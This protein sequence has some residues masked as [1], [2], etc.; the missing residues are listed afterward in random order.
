[1]DL[2]KAFY[3]D[4]LKLHQIRKAFNY[5]SEHSVSVQKFKCLEKVR[6]VVKHKTLSYDD[7]T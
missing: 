2:L 6:D 7:F 5:S 1:M 4:A 3:Y